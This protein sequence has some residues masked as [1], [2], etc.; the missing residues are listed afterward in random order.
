MKENQNQDQD[1]VPRESNITDNG[2][3]DQT[4]QRFMVTQG[5]NFHLLTHIESSTEGCRYCF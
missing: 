4:S 3:L 2:E 1:I 5:V